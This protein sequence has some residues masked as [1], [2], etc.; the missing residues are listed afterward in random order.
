VFSAYSR[1]SH[2]GWSVAIGMPPQFLNAGT[3]G[4]IT[5][6]GAGVLLS[7][8]FTVLAALLIARGINRPIG[9]LAVAAHAVGR[10][11]PFSPPVTDI[12][13]I[14]EVVDA[15]TTASI[16]HAHGEAEREQLLARE[17]EARAAAEA[18]NRAK[19][20]FLAML[21]HELRNPLGAISNAVRVFEHPRADARAVR[22]AR[23]IV[24]RQV[25]HLS[26]MTD[27]LLD[28][29]R[30]ITGKIAL[31]RKP[32]DLATAA[33]DTLSML[34]PRLAERRIVQELA[35]AWIDADLTRLEQII[36][37]LVENA[38]KYTEPGGMVRVTVAKQSGQAV[39][40]VADNGVG[41]PVEL[42][43]RVFELFVQGNRDLDRSHGGLGIGLTLARRLAELH[44][45][46]AEAASPG[47]SQ[48]S[49]F[50]VRFPLIADRIAET[51]TAKAM[52]LA[53]PRDIL[54]V[55][56]NA[57]ARESLCVL[58][59]Y[60]GH[61]V[62]VAADGIA[63]LDAALASPPD[64]ALIDVGLPRLDG[65]EL[66]RRLHAAH[67]SMLLVALTGYGL[68]DDRARALAAGFD[69]HLVKP[70]NEAALEEL[71]A[72]EARSKTPV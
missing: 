14:R 21:S 44:G 22:Q 57:D 64:V 20:E 24:G 7:I 55:E 56:D 10:G 34:K 58:L 27:D 29:A 65:Y 16:V 23:E 67:P 66:A 13:E 12:Q 5:V 35:P 6:F 1:S 3:L 15:L 25:D 31:H 46:S 19:D 37:N 49:E 41:M 62:R 68:P 60:A 52:S 63:G 4:S 61:R 51:R 69:A 39:L 28:A 43:A 36:A 59:E 30:A 72:R 71:I 33:A 26:R 40:R 8:V 38:V 18:A 50:I 47:P 45:G 32:V 53:V 70:V 17:Q 42:A 48:G 9:K 2:T 54:I 11:E